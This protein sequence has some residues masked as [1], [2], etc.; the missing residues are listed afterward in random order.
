MYRN[1]EEYQKDFNERI[2]PEAEKHN[3]K[4]KL[5]SKEKFEEENYRDKVEFYLT[6]EWGTPELHDIFYKDCDFSSDSEEETPEEKRGDELHEKYYDIVSEGY[7]K[8]YSVNQTARKA[9]EY[10]SKEKTI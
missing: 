3:I 10:F 7:S 1:Y 4:C 5:Q 6:E 2:A 9:Y 8:G